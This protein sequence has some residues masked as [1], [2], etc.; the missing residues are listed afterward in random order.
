MWTYT[1]PH[2]NTNLH[3]HTHTHKHVNPHMSMYKRI[4]THRHHTQTHTHTHTHSHSITSGL[5]RPFPWN[6]SDWRQTQGNASRHPRILPSPLLRQTNHCPG[7]RHKTHQSNRG[8][9]N[10]FIS[11]R[12]VT[13]YS[14]LLL[15]A[16]QE[17]VKWST[18]PSHDEFYL[19]FSIWFVLPA[20]TPTLLF[21]EPFGVLERWL[22][23]G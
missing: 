3:A 5:L 16:L 14:W 18:C 2:T 19:L 9:I 21:W 17:G 12:F 7:K 22:L 15:P 20:K 6:I 23:S 13:R 8:T 4:H 10:L 1:D 11:V